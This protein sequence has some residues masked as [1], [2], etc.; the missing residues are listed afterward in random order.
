MG[1]LPMDCRKIISRWT[2][3]DYYIYFRPIT[4]CYAKPKEPHHVVWVLLV[5]FRNVNWHQWRAEGPNLDECIRE[6]DEQIP[7]RVKLDP[8]YKPNGKHG[9]GSHLGPYAP[10]GPLKTNESSEAIADKQ[11]SKKVRR[12]EGCGNGH[13][14]PMCKG[15]KHKP[16]EVVSDKGS[17]KRK[18]KSKKK[19]VRK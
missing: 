19:K 8:G 5:E 12:C 17:E 1:N 14:P 9:R 15:K 2:R 6:L 13:A 16:I 3:D 7:R 18:K 10:A 4:S 11:R